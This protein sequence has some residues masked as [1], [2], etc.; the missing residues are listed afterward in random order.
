ML[1]T[2]AAGS[3]WSYGASIL[4]FVVP[5]LLFIFVAGG[6]WVAYTRP[7]LDP[8][9]RREGEQPSVITSPGIAD[10][11]PAVPAAEADRRA[12]ATGESGPPAPEGELGRHRLPATAAWSGTPRQQGCHGPVPDAA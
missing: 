12:E 9:H 10:V 6:L 7:H 2:A 11:M 8:A 1:I 3:A 5:M 4:T